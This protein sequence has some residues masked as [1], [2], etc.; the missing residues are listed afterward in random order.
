[1]HSTYT[2]VFLITQSAII[3]KIHQRAGRGSGNA[4]RV[5]YGAQSRECANTQE[6]T[7]VNALASTRD[8]RNVRSEKRTNAM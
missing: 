5:I 4:A 7:S 8:Q 1:M 2:P 6:N 3:C